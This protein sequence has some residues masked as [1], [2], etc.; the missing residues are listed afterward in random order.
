[1]LGNNTIPEQPEVGGDNND[2]VHTMEDLMPSTST[3]KK[4]TPMAISMAAPQ[5][6]NT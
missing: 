6:K 1:M 3:A 2:Q 4:G 5:K